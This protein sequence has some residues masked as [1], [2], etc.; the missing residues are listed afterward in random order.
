MSDA[1]RRVGDLNRDGRLDVAAA[2]N[3]GVDICL[4]ASL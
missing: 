3:T 1:L 2:T 4:N